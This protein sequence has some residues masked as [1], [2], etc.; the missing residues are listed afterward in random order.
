M[1]ANVQ[2][3]VRYLLQRTV[4]PRALNLGARAFYSKG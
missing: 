4:F 1:V 3:P 2:D